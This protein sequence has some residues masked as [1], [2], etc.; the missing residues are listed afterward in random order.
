MQGQRES[1]LDHL[2][3]DWGSCVFS[4]S[5]ASLVACS[6]AVGGVSD[7][8]NYACPRELHINLHSSEQH[9]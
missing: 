8:L 7:G 6:V 4:V 1:P 2:G 5:A 3:G 9:R